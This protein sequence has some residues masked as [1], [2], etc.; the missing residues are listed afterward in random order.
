M[1]M[2]ICKGMVWSVEECFVGIDLI[3]R[4]YL[5]VLFYNEIG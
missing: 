2:G 4:K 1:K 5:N 3:K